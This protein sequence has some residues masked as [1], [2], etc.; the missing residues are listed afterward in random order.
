[1]RVALVCP[2]AFIVGCGTTRVVVQER[3]QTNTVTETVKQPEPRVA[4]EPMIYVDTPAGLLYKPPSIS[5]YGGHQFIAHIRWTTYGGALALGKG[6]YSLDDCDPSCAEGHYTYTPVTVRLTDRKAC[7]GV[8]A[9]TTWSL[10]GAGLDATPAP[11]ASQDSDS[12]D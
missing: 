9:Y 2:V 5:Y 11:I 10:R 1:V 3:T 4:A 7:R 6:D 8:T 12:C